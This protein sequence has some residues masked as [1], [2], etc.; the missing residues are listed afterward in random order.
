MFGIP[1]A[2]K[3][4]EKCRKMINYSTDTVILIKLD[5]EKLLLLS[6]S[7]NDDGFKIISKSEISNYENYYYLSL[8]SRL[9]FKILQD[10][11]KAHWNNAEIGCHILWK[12]FPNV[13]DRALLYCLNFFHN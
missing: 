11:K 8:D 4:F 2:Y 3:K 1:N 6:L 5:K 12:R 9:L 7:G 13:Y 10:P